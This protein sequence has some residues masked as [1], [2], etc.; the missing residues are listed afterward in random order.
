[1]ANGNES[2]SSTDSVKGGLRIPSWA[3]VLLAALIYANMLGNS[4][5]YDDFRSVVD[6]PCISGEL[7][8]AEALSRDVWCLGPNDR[9]KATYSWRPLSTLLLKAV[10]AFFGLAVWAYHAFG[11]LLYLLAVWFAVRL[12]SR[13]SGSASVALAGGL[14]YAAHPVHTE[15]V[16]SISAIPELL[17]A[18]FFFIACFVYLGVPGKT[19]GNPRRWIAWPLLFL[20]ILSKES[21]VTGVLIFALIDIFH[22]FRTSEGRLFSKRPSKEFLL[23]FFMPWLFG[24]FALY[25]YIRMKLHLFGVLAPTISPSD[26]PLAG[27][28][29]GAYAP[30]AIS[31]LGEYIRL[32]V[33]PVRLSVDYSFNQIPLVEGFGHVAVLWPLALVALSVIFAVRLFRSAFA[34]AFGIIFIWATLSIVSNLPV[35]IPTL[36]AERLLLIPSFGLCLLAGLVIIRLREAVGG[37][38][39]R[40]LTAGIAVLLVLMSYRVITRNVDWRSNIPLFAASAKATPDS[41]RIRTNLGWWYRLEGRWDPAIEEYQAALAIGLLPKGGFLI[42]ELGL[43]FHAKGDWERALHYYRLAI[44]EK[45]DDWRLGLLLKAAAD[46]EIPPDLKQLPR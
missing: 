10:Y 36:V 39:A 41:W 3:P 33:W 16:A 44:K 8:L 29:F 7:H 23:A 6:N 31:A 27:Q 2:K 5:T 11:L 28:A 46:K 43:C 22:W 12:M 42:R 40:L 17:A 45:P 25:F 34:C 14:L 15:A 37:K 38:S 24:V 13:L 18:V 4:Y 20:A 26:N 9:D 19:G 35:T 21:A 32:L 1:M 30:T